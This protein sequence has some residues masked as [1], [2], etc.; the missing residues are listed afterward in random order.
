M[1]GEINSVHIVTADGVESWPPQPKD[2]VARALIAR[3]A[4]ALQGAST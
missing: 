4:A 3:I 1:G 2:D